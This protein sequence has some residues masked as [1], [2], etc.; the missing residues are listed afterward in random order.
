M[1][2]IIIGFL[3]LYLFVGAVI[4][5]LGRRFEF[6]TDYDDP[7]MAAPLITTLWPAL[8]IAIPLILIYNWVSGAR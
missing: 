1:A 7:E 3:F 8:L 6:I 5:G 4:A 2:L